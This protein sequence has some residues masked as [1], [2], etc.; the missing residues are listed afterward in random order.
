MKNRNTHSR[1]HLLETGT[2]VAVGSLSGCLSLSPDNSNG[3]LE[4]EYSELDEGIDGI[5]TA[6][7]TLLI[8]DS[9]NNIQAIDAK[10]GERLWYFEAEEPVKSLAVGRKYGSILT[11]EGVLSTFSVSDGSTVWE[12]GI[13]G[14]WN[15]AIE[16]GLTYIWQYNGDSV[17]TYTWEAY[18]TTTGEPLWS[19]KYPVGY[20]AWG[21][22]GSFV[23]TG[24]ENGEREEDPDG[25]KGGRV[26]AYSKDGSKSWSIRTDGSIRPGAATFT[27][28]GD[29]YVSLNP[30]Y[31]EAGGVLALNAGSE[32]W[33]NIDE[34]GPED[35][36][37]TIRHAP[38]VDDTNIY[39]ILNPEFEPA[40]S[41]KLVSYDR[42]TGEKNEQVKLPENNPYFPPEILNQTVYVLTVVNEA[43]KLAL[44]GYDASTL[45]KSIEVVIPQEAVMGSHHPPVNSQPVPVSSESVVVSA[46][47]GVLYAVTSS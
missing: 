1:R 37:W 11:R 4:W 15:T 20:P 7:S 42:E 5:H 27:E 13:G 3:T 14:D 39:G 10:S 18:K 17:G 45:E 34:G 44:T 40:P 47:G 24:M 12:K 8:S 26:I 33:R 32:Q 23:L 25:K 36:Y 38:L 22:D 16:S 28:G 19:N 46:I 35:K 29:V 43:G 6:G 2:L 31:E 21:S 30:V 9:G 41:R